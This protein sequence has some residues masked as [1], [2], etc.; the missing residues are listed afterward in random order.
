MTFDKHN[1]PTKFLRP[2]VKATHEH[3]IETWPRNWSVYFI[4]RH[5]SGGEKGCLTTIAKWLQ[6]VDPQPKPL[7]RQRVQAIRDSVSWALRD[8]SD[9]ELGINTDTDAVK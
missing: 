2:P 9:G 7:T 8:Y 3:A 4:A 6:Q 5:W 1:L